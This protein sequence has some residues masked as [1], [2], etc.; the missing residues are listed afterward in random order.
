M[1]DY[2][3]N[4]ASAGKNN[5]SKAAKSELL[6]EKVRRELIEKHVKGIEKSNLVSLKFQERLIENE[7]I[8]DEDLRLKIKSF[9]RPCDVEE[10][11]IERSEKGRCGWLQ[12]T[13]KIP[14]LPSQNSGSRWVLDKSQGQ[15]IDRSTLSLFCSSGCYYKYLYLLT[16]LSESPPHLRTEALN[17]IQAWLGLDQGVVEREARMEERGD[18]EK[19]L[20]L[21][22]V[23]RTPN[24]FGVSGQEGAK[25]LYSG[26]FGGCGSRTEE[27]PEMTSEVESRGLLGSKNGTESRNLDNI[28]DSIKSFKKNN[29]GYKYD[30]VIKKFD[31]LNISETGGD[32]ADHPG[33]KCEFHLDSKKVADTD[34]QRSQLNVE[35]YDKISTELGENEE[36]EEQDDEE[37]MQQEGYTYSNMMQVLEDLS[38]DYDCTED[39]DSDDDETG[40]K[41][42]DFLLLMSQFYD[43][44]SPEV[45]VLDLLTSLISEET[46]RLLTS[47][48]TPR[49]EPGG[50]ELRDPSE[51]DTLQRERRDVLKDMISDYMASIEWISQT[52]VVAFSVYKILDTFVFPFS[53]PNLK[54]SSLEL[55][56]FIFMQIIMDHKT[57]LG[58]GNCSGDSLQDQAKIQVKEWMRQVGEKYD[59]KFIDNIKLLFTSKD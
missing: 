18:E 46:K 43:Q 4:R 48:G 2:N 59:S 31:Y 6:R 57:Q 10:V 50:A 44:L 8:L 7:G 17:E 15:I 54:P 5:E 56:T 13:R 16:S 14:K 32:A 52:K 28:L 53:I 25:G 45:V 24:E 30:Q 39:Q 34:D 3:G 47:N 33:Q 26:S 42:E 55:L 19:E 36:E 20:A 49:R 51:F 1:S 12:C 22:Q 29:F 40:G 35:E 37:V 41:A 9:L 27:V 58:L 38:D 23:E 11:S 21:A